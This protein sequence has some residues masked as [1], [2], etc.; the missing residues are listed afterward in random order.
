MKHNARVEA[1]LHKDVQ[2]KEI[3]Y[4][5]I[6]TEKG[7]H[8]ISTGLKAVEKVKYLTDGK[9]PTLEKQLASKVEK[10]D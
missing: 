6:E 5:I 4:I 1:V 2:G 9:A 7:K 10:Q 8:I 3:P